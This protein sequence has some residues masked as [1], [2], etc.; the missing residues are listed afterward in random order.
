METT[1]TMDALRAAASP[2]PLYAELRDRGRVHRDEGLGAWLVT[3]HAEALGMLRNPAWS[4]DNRH[5][6]G[7]E[8][9]VAER[10]AAGVPD[11]AGRVMLFMDAPDHTRL[12]GLVSKAFTPRTVEALR[13]W[14]GALVEELL[15]Q[16]ADGADFMETVA[17]PLPVAVI[18]ELL[19][20]PESDRG[21]FRRESA[22]L[23]GTLEYRP[24]VSLLKA[25]GEA[26]L[27]IAGYLFEL[28]E[29]RRRAPRDDL[30]SLLVQA[31]EAGDRLLPEEL[32]STCILLLIAGHETTMN[33]LGNGL[34][35]LMDAPEEWGALRASPAFVPNAVEE[36][37]RYDSPVQLTVRTALE[38]I[39]L[40]GHRVP[41]GEQAIVLVGAANRDPE[42]FDEPDRLDVTRADA[43]HHLS[44]GHGAHFCLGAPLA[45][46]EAQ[47]AF[48]AMV[49]RWPRPPE[50]VEKPCFR[51]TLTLRGLESLPVRP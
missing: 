11:T 36:L 28:L 33:L 40:G 4:N 10:E 51:G 38:D 31:E 17:Y 37:L 48:A 25:A 43:R 3:G 26:I 27:A 50:L 18:C 30:L 14:V 49:R 45:R 19:G 22:R 32:L 34:L 42:R 46:L 29:E 12:R 1:L 15:D 5:A 9:W 44:L 39:E 13:P 6:A 47:E 21:L 2:Y 24:P 7:R 35:A 16:V 23:A 20:V 41:A 8:S